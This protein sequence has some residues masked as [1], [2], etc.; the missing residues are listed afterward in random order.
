MK[1]TE[2]GRHI[3]TV[4][5]VCPSKELEF[6]YPE[7]TRGCISLVIPWAWLEFALR[8]KDGVTCVTTTA[9]S[10]LMPAAAASEVRHSLSQ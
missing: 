4:T 3:E 5:V 9:S 6:P 2:A 10:M 8:R 1:E 7:E